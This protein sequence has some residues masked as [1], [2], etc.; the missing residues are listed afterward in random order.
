MKK[1]KLLFV[2]LII[3]IFTGCNANNLT[4]INQNKNLQLNKQ[5]CILDDCL[6]VQGLDT[7][8]IAELNQ[9]VKSALL[10]ALDDEYKA[11]STYEAV[12]N[13]FGTVRPFIMIIRAEEQHATSL[14]SLFDKYGLDIPRNNYLSNIQAPDT[15]SL[16]CQLG[17]AAEIA[18]YELYENLLLKV[19]DYP[20]IVDVFTNLMNASKEKHLPA[21]EKC[22]N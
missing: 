21:F 7:Y 13:K 3:F 2:L 12:I 4:G 20:D 16:S 8:P 1:F 11:Y 6:I 18:N 22:A 9:E 5:N 19:S 10:A 17:V 14:K 15:F